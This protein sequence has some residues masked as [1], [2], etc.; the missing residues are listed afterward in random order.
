M[1]MNSILTHK[2]N[3]FFIAFLLIGNVVSAQFSGAFAPAN[4][5]TVKTPSSGNGF[6]NTGGAPASILIIG[7]DNGGIP[8][9]ASANTEFQILAPSAG[10][11]TATWSFHTNDCQGAY[12]DP[13]YYDA[14][15]VI[16]QLTDDNG[17]VDQSGT[18]AFSVLAGQVIGFGVFARDN[19]CG[20]AGLTLSNFHFIDISCGKKGDK[21]SICHKPTENNA[22]TLCIGL[23]GLADHIGHGDYVGP[24]GSPITA[25]PLGAKGGGGNLFTEPVQPRLSAEITNNP[26]KNYFTFKLQGLA[27]EKIKLTLT[28][29]TGRVV[30]VKQNLI[31]GQ[32]LQVGQNYAPGIYIA[33]MIQGNSRRTFKLLKTD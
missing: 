7:S 31:S 33:E 26:T 30:E 32:T 6:V 5:T 22:Q 8:L 3:W 2:A 13:A 24:C 29:A 21:I 11:V 10:I 19:Y 9:G 4:W 16:T 12:W 18:L 23:D 20:N 27:T 1:K 25:S 28:D 14:N 17:P 15:G